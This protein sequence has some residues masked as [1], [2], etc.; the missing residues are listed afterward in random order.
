[1]PK[2]GGL[3]MSWNDPVYDRSQSDILA[4]TSKAFLNVVDW[5]RING[6]T[7]IIQVLVRVIAGVDVSLYELDEP[8]ITDFP[9]AD[10][11]NQF[12]ENIEN[13]RQEAAFPVE[14][15]VV[16]LKYDYL[17]G[18]GAVVPDFNDVNDWERDLAF[19]RDYL[20]ASAN[21]MRYCG[22]FNCGQPLYWQN[23]FRYFKFVP[24][25]YDPKRYPRM[26]ATCGAGLTR[27]N[28]WRSPFD[29]RVRRPRCGIV[30]CG[31]GMTRQNYFRRYANA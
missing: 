24:D 28:R 14:S 8:V 23:R 22:T 6:N 26:G 1:M 10:E 12:I 20:A 5:I 13:L 31:T 7:Q 2:S 18:S 11:I 3:S 4:R 29:E 27:Q 17:S 30:V 9:T 16:A 21:Y 25:A 15:G 19:I